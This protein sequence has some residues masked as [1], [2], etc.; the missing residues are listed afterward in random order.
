MEINPK[1]FKSREHIRD[2]V[3]ARMC[4]CIDLI[5][6][7]DSVDCSVLRDKYIKRKTTREIIALYLD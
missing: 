3:C 5:V 7:P 6:L 1:C 4:V 2:A